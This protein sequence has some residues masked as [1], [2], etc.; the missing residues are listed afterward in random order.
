MISLQEQTRVDRP[1]DECFAYVADFRS[2]AEWDATAFE[3]RKTTDGPVALGTEF[4]V[5][6]K[7]PVGSILIDYTVTEFDAPHRVALAARCWAFE[8]EDVIS[9]ERDG[10]GTQITYH[11]DFR[12]HAP[13]AHLEALLRSGMERMGK[14]AVAGLRRALADD[15]APPETTSGAARADRLLWPG[16]AMFSKLGYRRGRKRVFKPISA[17]LTGQRMVVTGASSGLGLATARALAA[18][19][20]DLVLV[21]R[22]EEKARRVVAGLVEESGNRQIRYEIADLALMRDVDDLA[23]RLLAE[24]RPID[25]LINNAGALFNEWGETAEGIEQSFAL[26][27][28][29]PWRLTR[30]LHPLL[31]A[32]AKRGERGDSRVINVV[33]GGMYSQR[34]NVDRLEAEPEGYQ[35]AV[36]YAR[37]K[38]ALTVVTEQWAEAWAGDGIVVNAMHPGWADT[39]GVES[40]LP[41]FHKITRTILRTPEEGADTIVWL[42]AATE[43]GEI[44]GKLY[45]DREPRTT[46]LL[47]RTRKG[48]T[49]EERD[50]LLRFLQN[51]PL[52]AQAAA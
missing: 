33:S 11:A 3:A 32:A 16:L 23:Q 40:S 42:A 28:L 20:A 21:M 43:A 17:S 27:L 4:E 31:V 6:C 15:F 19:G 50:R 46:H 39:P 9:F 38:R 44:S 8:G 37:C 49:P 13:F 34:L 5:R 45:L 52:E 18:R 48:D 7:L 35:G 24:D 2:S 30:A 29:S 51:Y 1:I 14:V 12:F 10:D 25:V 22:N 41:G 47:E 36:A 26:L